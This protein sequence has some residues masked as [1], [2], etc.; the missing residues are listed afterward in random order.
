MVLV[1]AALASVVVVATI[2]SSYVSSL[3]NPQSV[4]NIAFAQNTCDSGAEQRFPNT[5]IPKNINA[6][7][8]CIFNSVTEVTT[9]CPKD[10]K[11]VPAGSGC[12]DAYCKCTKEQYT[13]FQGKCQFLCAKNDKNG[14]TPALSSSARTSGGTQCN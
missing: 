1:I 6:M 11:P 9:C 14:Q 12:S 5:E 13:Y 3:L 2:S 10:M 4:S 8:Q 7:K